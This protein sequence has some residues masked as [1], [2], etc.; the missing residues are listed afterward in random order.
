MKSKLWTKDFLII[1]LENFFV[2]FTYYLLITVIAVYATE[3]FHASP[4]VAGLSAGIFILGA[5]LGRL[6]GGSSIERI[7]HKKMLYLSFACY[8]VT[9]L[10]Y[11]AVNGLAFLIV[12]RFLHGAAFGLTSTATGTIAAEIIPNERRG[13]GTGY[14][15]LSMTL[16]TAIGPFLGMFLTQHANFKANLVVCAVA[17]SMSFVAAF[18]LT[19]PMIEP[20]CREK[21][22]KK[23]IVWGNFFEVKAVPISI[24]T[25]LIC[26]GYSSILA[27]LSSYVKSIHLIEAGSFFFLTYAIAILVS[28][29]FTGYWFDRKG[30]N[31][32]I[33]PTFLLFAAAL[34]LLGNAHQGYM[35]LLAAVILGFGYGNYFASGQALAVKVSPQNRKALATSTYFIFADLGSGI[36]PFLLGVVIPVLGYRGLYFGMAAVVLATGLVYYFLHGKKAALEKS[37]PTLSL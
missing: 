11:F 19:V 4:S 28:R 1:N 3:K 26:F 20:A 37:G 21:I 31:F 8:L 14:Y 18:S 32:I 35:V 23:G 36:G 5:I 27:F 12:I 2:Y 6:Y 10:L 25:G 22:T 15:A 9:T 29:P 16:A 34:V 33:Y 17:L 7:G 13:E 24:V 30:E